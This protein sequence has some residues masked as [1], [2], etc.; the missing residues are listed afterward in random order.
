LEWPPKSGKYIEIP[1]VDKGGWFSYDTAKEK[2]I[3]GQIPILEELYTKLT[4]P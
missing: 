2:I 3:P 4:N 1:E